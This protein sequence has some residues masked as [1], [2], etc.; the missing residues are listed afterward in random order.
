MARRIGNGLDLAG[1]RIQGVGDPTAPADAVNLQYLTNF[2]QGMR[3]KDPVRAA[4]TANVNLAAPGA[5]FD[6]VALNNGDRLLVKNQTAGA[7]NGIYV[8]AGASSPLV[9]ALDADTA[10]ELRSA[11]VVVSEGTATDPAGNLANA[12]RAWLQRVDS[13]TLG[14][15]PLSWIPLPGAGTTYTNGNG[16]ALSGVTFSVQAVSGGGIVVTAG[17]VQVDALVVSRHNERNVG[18]GTATTLTVPHNLARRPLPVTLMNVATGALEDTDVTFVD[19]NTVT[20]T[21]AAAPGA[22]AYRVS[23]G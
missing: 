3:F 18:D 6:G 8:F 5:S 13:I 10:A 22:N 9:R 23:V 7:E 4:T 11:V 2:L 16:L 17:G 19:D 12:D 21:F 14:S 20:L 15:T 1:Q